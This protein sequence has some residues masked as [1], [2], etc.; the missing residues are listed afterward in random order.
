M[1]KRNVGCELYIRIYPRMKYIHSTMERENICN[2]VK[3]KGG[4]P[5]SSDLR[6]LGIR[7]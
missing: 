4:I 3:K 1:H 2:I 6:G 7:E 5:F